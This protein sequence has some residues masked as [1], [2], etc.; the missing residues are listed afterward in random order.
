[1]DKEQLIHHAIEKAYRGG[2]S[3]LVERVKKSSL[4]PAQ[5]DIVIA[6]Y[7]QGNR[8]LYE[9][10]LPSFMEREKPLHTPQHIPSLLHNSAVYLDLLVDSLHKFISEIKDS[11]AKEESTKFHASIHTVLRR[12]LPKDVTSVKV[13]EEIKDL[14]EDFYDWHIRPTL[15]A[16]K[17]FLELDSEEHGKVP[18]KSQLHFWEARKFIKEIYTSLVQND[19]YQTI[20]KRAIAALGSIS[21]DRIDKEYPPPSMERPFLV[22]LHAG[23]YFFKYVAKDRVAR[24]T[25]R[26]EPPLPNHMARFEIRKR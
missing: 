5:G 10:M 1:M 23:A 18:T 4:Q 9:D 24:E 19:N 13:S 3:T 14:L 2:Q 6:L 7:E 17:A 22:N 12:Y 26:P 16:A 8:A 20:A 25:G 15:Y 11:G 21:A